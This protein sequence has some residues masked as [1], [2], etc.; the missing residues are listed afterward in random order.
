M[1]CIGVYQHVAGCY[2]G[3]HAVKILGWGKD[4]DG[5]PY[6]YVWYVYNGTRLLHHRH[7]WDQFINPD[8]RGCP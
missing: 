2:V 5:T 4:T 1:I 8:F 6:W 3:G 7:Y